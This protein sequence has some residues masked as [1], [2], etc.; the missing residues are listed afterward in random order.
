MEE[1]GLNNRRFS[2]ARGIASSLQ[3]CDFFGE[4][5]FVGVLFLERPRP[6]KFVK[7]DEKWFFMTHNKWISIFLTL[8]AATL[9][10]QLNAA[11]T[12]Y[13]RHLVFNHNS[14][15]ADYSGVC[16][17]SAEAAHAVGHYEFIYGDD[18]KLAEIDNY[19]PEDWRTHALTHLGAFRTTFSYED[20][21]VVRRFF[22][23]DGARVKNLRNV[24]EEDYFYDKDGFKTALELR[25]LD[26]KPMESNWNIS[27]YTWEKKGNLVV[28]RRYNSK[29]ELVPL[30]QYFQFHISGMEYNKSGHICV[31]YNLND[32]LEVTENPDGIAFYT[33]MVSEDGRMLE[34]TYRNKDGEIIRS[35][36]MYAIV[37]LTYDKDGN[38][39]AEDH[40]DRDG[41]LETHEEFN[42]D[43]A[44]KLVQAAK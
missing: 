40:L 10:S 35:P 13:Y 11:T 25:D 21:R 43:A 19:S 9:A 24:F 5:C 26:G 16:E 23:K 22:D 31:H 27:R 14:P 29:G 1:K 30:S 44:G 39:V 28:E 20:G 4:L 37:R 2:K 38:V 36:W 7:L 32:K 33:D 34:I 41:T 12:R 8:L 6:L 18:G 15:V 17:I 3:A 42:Y